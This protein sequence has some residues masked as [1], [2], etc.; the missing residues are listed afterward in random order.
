MKSFGSLKSRM[1]H[2]DIFD[3]EDTISPAEI[4][5][6]YVLAEICPHAYFFFFGSPPAA[7]D[8]LA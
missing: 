6:V 7:S 5:R 2:L 4:D 3:T 8:A 1:W